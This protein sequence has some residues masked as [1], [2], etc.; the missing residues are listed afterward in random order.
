[1]MEKVVKLCEEEEN[2]KY[3]QEPIIIENVEIVEE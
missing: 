3:Y 1:M 2:F